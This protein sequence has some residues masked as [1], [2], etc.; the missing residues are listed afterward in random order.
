LKINRK[1]IRTL[2]DKMTKRKSRKMPK[3]KL[4]GRERRLAKG[5][6]GA[7]THRGKPSNMLKK[8]RKYFAVDWE[9]AIFELTALGVEFDA[10]YLAR[11][12]ENI[13]REFQDEKK[14]LPISRLE[15]D[16]YH[17]IAPDSDENFAYI[18]AYTPGGAPFGVTW[19]EWEEI[20]WDEED[21]E[22]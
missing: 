5:P 12:R 4:K 22:P 10:A 2:N 8:Y 13:S 7:V 11:L 6:D 19:E 16:A 15:F 18:A 14:H 3:Q 1:A 17:G 21:R 20:D 9:C